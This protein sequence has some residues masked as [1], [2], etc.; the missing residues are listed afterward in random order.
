M[1]VF[2]F[3]TR[4][5]FLALFLSMLPACAFPLPDGAAGARALP[6]VLIQ[7]ETVPSTL[8]QSE[9]DRLVE[10]RLGLYRLRLPLK[11]FR[12]QIE[13]D[14][15]RR[16]ELAMWL[17][18]YRP[19]LMDPSVGSAT[20]AAKLDI[21]VLLAEG[22]ES[23]DLL[24]L[25]MRQEPLGP[26]PD[27]LGGEQPRIRGKPVYGLS[28]FYV[29]TDLLVEQAR[30]RGEKDVSAETVASGRHVDRYLGNAVTD[31]QVPTYIECT[32]RALDDG[33][34]VV[35][36]QLRRSATANSDLLAVCD[37]NFMLDNT[38]IVGSMHYSRAY[39]AQWRE[40]EVHVS[41]QLRQAMV[42]DSHAP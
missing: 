20:Q 39:L 37:H 31:G 7:I 35:N 4:W 29:D 24:S 27:P 15:G 19:V 41:N 36:A 6:G 1:P 34:H 25:W 3:P 8:I 26:S 10:A 11:Y 14:A 22:V 12:Y 28:A 16:F 5:P 42:A 38:G 21:Q 40:I 23:V 33:I 30:A 2:R 18:E 13:P 9:D 17:P 32:T